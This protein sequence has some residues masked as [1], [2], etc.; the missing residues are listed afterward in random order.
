MASSP[1]DPF[2]LTC[3][4]LFDLD[5]ADDIADGAAP[6]ASG[7]VE[8]ETAPQPPTVAERVAKLDLLSPK[9]ID[10]RLADLG[11][12]GQPEARRAAAVLG[13]RHLRRLR[14]RHLDG[15]EPDS[16]L[17]DNLLLLG[18]TGAG[19]SF[20]V[21]LLFREVLGVPAVSVSTG[22]L[23]EATLDNGAVVDN[24]VHLALS[25]LY[26]AAERD[27]QWAGCGIVCI[28][29]L[30]E[31]A[32]PVTHMGPEGNVAR[33]VS[34]LGPFSGFSLRPDPDLGLGGSTGMQ[35]SLLHLMT[36]P[37]EEILPEPDPAAEPLPEGV[38]PPLVAID[39]RC[40]PIVVCG[41]LSEP[42]LP[43]SGLGFGPQAAR[44]AGNLPP[45]RL[46][47][48]PELF[49][50]FS[51][52]VTLDAL[53]ADALHLVLRDG[54]L[55]AFTR[56]FADEGLTLEVDE[57]ARERVVRAALARGTGAR[58]LRA[59]LA[60][61]LETAAFEHFGSPGGGAVRLVG[62]GDEV[63]TEVSPPG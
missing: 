37:R 45:V 39:L 2:D 22:L 8:G 28:D 5:I 63:R 10:A 55:P 4:P 26:A 29:G 38:D 18:P 13:Y 14:R 19:K 41:I 43:V 54:V 11:Y 25:E 1:P 7:D 57:A 60:P 58:G 32:T 62:V 42:R 9:E 56:E 36:A 27:E 6:G 31:L 51:R 17:R 20:L 59:A 3:E 30:D 24:L 61:L 16:G 50:R 47:V 35:R 49:G 52:T 53:D 48:L 21:E 34:G 46:S 15:V 12:H 40:V 44:T 33:D 23:S